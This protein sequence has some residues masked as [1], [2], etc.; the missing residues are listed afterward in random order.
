MPIYFDDPSPL[1]NSMQHAFFSTFLL[2]QKN[3]EKKGIFRTKSPLRY[4]FAF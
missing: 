3:V 4:S 1:G 2:F